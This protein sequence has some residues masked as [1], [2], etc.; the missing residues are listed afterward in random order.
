MLGFCPLTLWIE[1]RWKNITENIFA[2]Y[3]Q[4]PSSFYHSNDQTF[5]CYRLPHPDLQSFVLKIWF[6]II[7]LI[8]LRYCILLSAD[9]FFSIMQINSGW[10]TAGSPFKVNKIIQGWCSA[11]SWQYSI[12]HFYHLS[13]LKAGTPEAELL[14]FSFFFGSRY[15]LWVCSG[16]Q[17]IIKKSLEPQ[18]GH[19]E[20]MLHS[21]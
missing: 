15:H 12:G 17:T 16:F 21:E 18:M 6:F 3:C 11:L 7:Y 20:P 19:C 9:S 4:N 8:F 2:S 5:L 10:K 14:V 13:P 1:S